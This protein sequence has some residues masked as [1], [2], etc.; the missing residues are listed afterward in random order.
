MHFM[1]FIE[2]EYGIFNLKMCKTG[3]IGTQFVGPCIVLFLYD[4][5]EKTCFGFHIDDRTSIQAIK[6][7]VNEY[8]NDRIVSTLKAYLA[9]GWSSSKADRRGYDQALIQWLKSRGIKSIDTQCIDQIAGHGS[10]SKRENYYE[11]VAFD[12]NKGNLIIQHGSNPNM[13]PYDLRSAAEQTQANECL[14]YLIRDVGAYELTQS[15]QDMSSRLP[16]IF[17]ANT[18]AF[19]NSIIDVNNATPLIPR[20]VSDTINAQLITLKEAI[21]SSD[22]LQ[23]LRCIYL[24]IS[25]PIS[26][27]SNSDQKYTPL[28]YA[29]FQLK[30]QDSNYHRQIIVYILLAQGR[31]DLV[32]LKGIAALDMLDKS[33]S[34]TGLCKSLLA[35]FSNIDNQNDDHNQI[36]G[37]V[38]SHLANLANDVIIYNNAAPHELEMVHMVIHNKLHTMMAELIRFSQTMLNKSQEERNTTKMP[39]NW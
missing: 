18:Q 23:V 36:A 31:R 9:G 22:P 1:N 20:N 7:A 8:L 17:Y 27:L 32:N 11:V 37:L 21:V 33:S 10:D 2:R 28:H 16:S 4:E 26:P 34:F 14:E 13:Q 29:C 12:I 3:V 6:N 25:N 5:K 19:Y 24:G 15:I 38:R 35:L 39:I 30:S